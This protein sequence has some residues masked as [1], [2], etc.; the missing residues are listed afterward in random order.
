MR[1]INI[2]ILYEKK[3]RNDIFDLKKNFLPN[4]C[5]TV[6]YD[7]FLNIFFFQFKNYSYTCSFIHVEV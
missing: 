3:L 5:V 1:S 4:M 6:L 7:L 2:I